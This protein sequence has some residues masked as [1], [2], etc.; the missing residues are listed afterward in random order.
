MLVYKRASPVHINLNPIRFLILKKGKGD[1]EQERKV[2]H[3][4]FRVPRPRDDDGSSSCASR[5]VH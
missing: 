5:S 1:E 2:N 4:R 3:T